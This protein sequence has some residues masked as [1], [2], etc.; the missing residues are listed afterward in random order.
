MSS[1]P[2]YDALSVGDE[3]A[4]LIKGVNTV[5]ITMYIATVWL[6]DRIHFDYPFSVQ[7]RG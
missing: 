6:M 5:N 4:P 3:I 2:S 7:R 1:E